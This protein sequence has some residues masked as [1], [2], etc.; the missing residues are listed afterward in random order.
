VR[1]GGL[2][3]AAS[4][5]VSLNLAGHRFRQ[6][7]ERYQD[8]GLAMVHAIDPGL[9]SRVSATGGD[10]SKLSPED[11]TKVWSV[12]RRTS[13]QQAES[14]L[15]MAPD[16]PLS[17]FRSLS[18]DRLGG[19]GGAGGAGPV[20]RVIDPVQAKQQFADLFD[21]L[22]LQQP[23]EEMQ[24]QLVGWLQGQLDAAEEGMNFDASARIREFV[25]GTAR[26]K[27][28][29]AAKPAGMNPQE[30]LG[31]FQS[32]ASSMLGAEAPSVQSLESGLKTGQYQTTVGATLSEQLGRP[33]E[34]KNSRMFGRLAEVA[35]IFG[36]AT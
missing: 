2:Q 10:P 7:W 35:D 23:P 17:L 18:D 32:A 25:E 22:L 8:V 33:D 21:A 5:Q 12:I 15:D 3:G 20:R 1:R 28:L 13:G 14:W 34:L 31:M 36:G 11:E 19:S 6:G 16:S 9:A 24:N 4:S 27:E 30:Y 26:F 29:Y